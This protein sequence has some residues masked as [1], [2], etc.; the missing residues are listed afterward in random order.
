MV[1]DTETQN[2]KI[3]NAFSIQDLFNK[4]MSGSDACIPCKADQSNQYK[5]Q[6]DFYRKGAFLQLAFQKIFACAIKFGKQDRT[7]TAKKAD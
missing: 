6:N 4:R 2:K 5:N 1:E 7:G 3:P